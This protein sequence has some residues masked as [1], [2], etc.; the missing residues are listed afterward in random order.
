MTE[1]RSS[2]TWQWRERL[3]RGFRRFGGLLAIFTLLI[4]L[5]ISQVNVYVKTYSSIHFKYVH[6]IVCQLCLYIVVQLLSRVGLF[7]TPWTAA[8][9]ASLSF[10]ISQSLLKFMSIESEILTISFFDALFF[11]LQSFPA[12]GSF[13]VSWLFTSCGPSIGAS[14]SALVL[15]V[16]IQDWFPFQLTGLIS[17]L[18]KGLARVYSSSTIQKHQ[19]FDIQSSLGPTLCTWLLEKL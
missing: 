5:M 18:S 1:T 2:V 16:N 6:F 3:R 11:C 12:S 13:P 7:M 9:Q 8:C 10:T 15:S 19:F 17:L 14:A 4:K